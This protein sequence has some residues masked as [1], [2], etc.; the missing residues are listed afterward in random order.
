VDRTTT[1]R[2]ESEPLL[3]VG[4]AGAIGLK[5]M[6]A[7]AARRPGGNRSPEHVPGGCGH[8]RQLPDR[9]CC[10]KGF[11]FHRMLAPGRA[12]LAG[13]IELVYRDKAAP[14]I[15]LMPFGSSPKP[16]S[17]GSRH[18]RLVWSQLPA[19]RKSNGAGAPLDRE[20]QVRNGLPGVGRWIRTLG[21][22]RGEC[23]RRRALHRP[24][25]GAERH[26][27]WIRTLGPRSRMGKSRCATK[28]SPSVTA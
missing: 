11:R 8:R 2:P 24:E 12:P 19:S 13:L 20:S 17:I 16:V 3:S 23:C 1:I 27:D 15:A 25:A 28:R 22:P 18:P 5:A 6:A 21:P 9:S 26:A 14:Q 7:G 10:G 4:Q